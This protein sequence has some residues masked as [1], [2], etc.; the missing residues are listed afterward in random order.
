MRQPRLI[1]LEIEAFR[2]FGN[3]QRIDLDADVV[4][5]RGDNGTG[6]TSI[7]DA[8]LWVTTGSL[9]HLSERVK[10]LRRVDDPI[11][12]RYVTPP[13][14]VALTI[15]DAGTT[16]LFERTGSHSRTA[17]VAQRD[18]E[19]VQGAEEVLARVFN[20]ANAT[21]L[22]AAVRAWGVLRQDALQAALEAGAALHERLSAVVGLER[23]NAFA[24]AT[25]LTLKEITHAR[26]E[27]KKS[28]TNLRDQQNEAQRRVAEL[29]L[30]TPVSVGQSALLER[31]RSR[32]LLSLPSGV[33]FSRKA[34]LASLEPLAQIGSDIADLIADAQI[35]ADQYQQ[36]STIRSSVTVSTTDLEAELGALQRQIEET[37]EDAPRMIQLAEAAVH[38]LSDTCPVCGQTIDQESVR[39]QL[40]EVLESA[41]SV[42]TA[43]ADARDA[44]AGARARLADAR[45]AELRRQEAETA[46]AT[47]LEALRAKLKISNAI[48]LDEEWLRPERSP[49]L[50]SAL[51]DLRQ[52]LRALYAEAGRDPQEI[53]ARASR[54]LSS[55]TARI[56][57]AESTLAELE[58]RC[59]RATTLNRLAHEAS[60]RIVERALRRL[61][62]TFAEV[63]DRLAPHPTFTELRAR[64]DIYYGKNHVV[65][66]VYDPERRIQA[67]PLL[68][69]SEGQLNVVALSY[70]LGL[71]LNARDGALPFIVLDDPLQA[72]DAVA[73]LGFSDLCRRV[74]ETRQLVVTTHDRRFAD[75]LVRKLAPRE[76]GSRPWSTS[77]TGGRARD[78]Y[79]TV[80]RPPWQR[81]L[82]CSNGLH[83][84]V[85][86]R[87]D[88]AIE[89]GEFPP[90]VPAGPRAAAALGGPHRTSV[91]GASWLVVSQR[92]LEIKP[93]G[94]VNSNSLQTG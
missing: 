26:N 69:Y 45:A 13:A 70:F 93:V 2:G 79:F 74:R 23:V 50:V 73:V 57:D 80:M 77:S 10:G 56:G 16:W 36:L 14:R 46:T 39:A 87:V 65:P 12:N 20:Q 60:Q 54:E 68:V 58:N 11:V 33:S 21:A 91:A 41:Q 6:K 86:L 8:L 47:A 24:R 53:V 15:D 31:Y 52:E 28:L 27:A 94:F 19:Q 48:A 37:F 89:R 32:I 62:P 83:R 63:F 5:I 75:V 61:E 4:V 40:V 34:D 25:D 1:S 30:Q 51:E 17:L 67:N 72:M 81:S 71:A 59:T 7:V 3:P 42:L 29:Q 90:T 85:G 38:L 82:R 92:R 88:E 76:A 84:R 78:Q 55:L 44:A 35:V 49:G 43:V 18:D 22:Q 64:Q 9:P 66:E